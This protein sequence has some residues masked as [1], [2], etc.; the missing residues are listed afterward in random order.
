MN[1]DASGKH[2]PSDNKHE[3]SST[4]DKRGRKNTPWSGHLSNAEISRP[5][6]L[7]LAALVR[8]T[9]ERGMQLNELAK[10]LSVTYGYINQLRNGIRAVS[11]ISDDF[12]LACSR[13]LGIPRLTVL[14]LAGRITPEDLFEPGA[15]LATEVSNAIGF[16]CDDKAW[17]HLIT[18]ELRSSCSHSKFAIVRLYEAATGKVLMDRTLQLE[19]LAEE[20]SRLQE[21]GFEKP[22]HPANMPSNAAK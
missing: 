16:V 7:L 3:G 14:M 19:S 10:E 11:Q 4:D 5:G 18:P 12:A 9:N 22:K 13:F 21:H 1:T 20:I 6:G 15:R 17:G 2:E 8:C